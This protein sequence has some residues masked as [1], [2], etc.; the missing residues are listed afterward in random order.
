M[1]N[2]IFLIKVWFTHEYFLRFRKMLKNIRCTV[3]SLYWIFAYNLHIICYV[4]YDDEEN[5]N[6]MKKVNSFLEDEH[7]YL[8]QKPFYY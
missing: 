8:I 2:V 1:S 5:Q 6:F 4:S 3:Q 7:N